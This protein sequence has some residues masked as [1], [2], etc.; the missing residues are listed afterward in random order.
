MDTYEVKLVKTR[1][2][3]KLESQDG[4]PTKHEDTTEDTKI[5]DND[6]IMIDKSVCMEDTLNNI[7]S[8]GNDR[9]ISS[10]L[11]KANVKKSQLKAMKKNLTQRGYNTG[12]FVWLSLLVD[13]LFI[14]LLFSPFFS[15]GMAYY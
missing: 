3:Q 8:K 11:N 13:L 15:F 5:L 10:E 12:H 14:I 4:H 1:S 9:S 6:G 2:M 7:K